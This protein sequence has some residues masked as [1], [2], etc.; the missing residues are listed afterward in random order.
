MPTSRYRLL[1]PELLVRH[2]ARL[3]ELLPEGALAVLHANDPQPTNADGLMPFKQ[4]SNFYYLSGVDEPAGILLLFPS[5]RD[6]KLREVLFLHLKSAQEAIWE[7]ESLGIQGARALSGIQ[8]I[9]PLQDFEKIFH[10]LMCEAQQVYLDSNEHYRAEVVVETRTARFISDCQRR[11][12]LHTRGRL[13]P[14]LAQLRAV[15]DKEEVTQINQAISITGAGFKEVLTHLRPNMMEYEIEGLVLGRFVA[16][17]SRGFAYSPIVA[18]GANAC[19]LHYTANAAPCQA[20]ELLLMDIG[21]EYGNYCADMTRVIPV[22][23]RFNDRQRAVY[24]AVLAAFK[25]AKS[26]LRAGVS[27]KEYQRD[28]E[29]CI[30]EQLLRLGVLTQDEVKTQDPE[31]PAFKQ[32]F[33]HGVSHHLGLDVHDVPSMQAPLVAGA[34]L[35]VE[36]GIYLKKEGIG[37]RLENDVVITEEGCTDL[38]AEVPLEVDEIEAAMQDKTTP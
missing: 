34:V 38:M 32:Y 4:N 23:G 10:V 35:T 8:N 31:S 26:C 16:G 21:A 18:S 15:K 28:V 1:P 24:E 11:Y 14:L 30:E 37:I 29:T 19:V 7:G 12:P 27:L 20:G 36:P 17:G 9:Q 25:Y 2:R 22:S 5:A 33:M 6:E 3:A 13:A